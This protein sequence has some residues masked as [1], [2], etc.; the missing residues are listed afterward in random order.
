VFEERAR[1]CELLDAPDCDPQLARQSYRFMEG[2]N[3]SYGGVRTVLSALSCELPS[4]EPDVPVRILDLGAGSCDIP[5]AVARWA[6]ANGRDVRITC[7][8][9]KSDALELARA[10]LPDWSNASVTLEQADIFE[11]EPTEPFDYALASMVLHHFSA[12]EIATLI[13]HVRPFV[14]RALI[15][16]DLRRSLVNYL[17]CWFAVRPWDRGVRH[18][19]LL[20]VRRGFAPA[21]LRA[22]LRDH[23]PGVTVSTAWFCRVVGIV[24][25]DRE[26]DG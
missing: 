25:F 15:V 12:D 19:A 13:R 21:E 22:I 14:R 18:D 10:C 23:D 16:N 8:D 26:A 6:K 2:V 5:L 9:Q 11:Y 3:R 1:G 24:R 4:W 20:S 17:A 7:I